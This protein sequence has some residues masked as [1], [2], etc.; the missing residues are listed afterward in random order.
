MQE[1]TARL[2]RPG[3]ISFVGPADGAKLARFDQIA[4]SGCAGACAKMGRP[5]PITITGLFLNAVWAIQA[6]TVRNELLGAGTG[7]P[8]QTFFFARNP[9][10]DGEVIEVRELDGPRAG[11]RTAHPGP[12]SRRRRPERGV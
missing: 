5:V 3:M 7:E 1:D 11:R 6:Q 4:S 12:R 8:N 2:V 10:L 9:V